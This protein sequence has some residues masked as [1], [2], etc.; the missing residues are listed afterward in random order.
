MAVEG[1][2]LPI[3]KAWNFRP[4]TLVFVWN[5][6]FQNGAPYLGMGFYTRS[7]T[8]TC[9]LGIR[10]SKPRNKEATGISQVI[11]APRRRH[12]QKPDEQYS[13]IEAL[14]S[15]PYLELFARQQRPG[16]TSWGNEV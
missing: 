9:L 7:G 3:F 15:G 16:W 13:K 1:K 11:T 12:S 4:V 10:G 6:L 5:K 14:Y 8:E 2:H